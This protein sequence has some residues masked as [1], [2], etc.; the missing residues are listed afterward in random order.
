MGLLSSLFARDPLPK[1]SKYHFLANTHKENASLVLEAAEISGFD[2]AVGDAA[3]SDNGV[4]LIDYVAIYTKESK[5]HIAFWQA[6][7]ELISKREIGI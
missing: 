5:P 6:F 7:N 4:K 2:M 3:Y 1:Q